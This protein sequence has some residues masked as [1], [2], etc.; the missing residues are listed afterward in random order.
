MCV[1]VCVWVGVCVYIYFVFMKVALNPHR[2]SQMSSARARVSVARSS[3]ATLTLNSHFSLPSATNCAT[4]YQL[5]RNL[6]AYQY[7]EVFT[8]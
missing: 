8:S 1:S 3:R 6:P 2:N 4:V 7:V 5:S